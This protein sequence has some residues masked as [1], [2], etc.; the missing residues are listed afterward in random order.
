M[1]NFIIKIIIILIIIFV[2]LFL[3]LKFGG[4]LIPNVCNKIF[5]FGCNDPAILDTK[6][7]HWTK[8]FRDNWNVILQEYNNYTNKF[9]IPYHHQLNSYVSDCDIKRMWKT[10]YLRAYNTDTTNVELFP[11]T[12]ELINNSP[13]TLAFFSVLEPGAK[14][15]PHKGIYKGVIRYHLGLVVPTDTNNCFIVVDGKKLTWKVGSD[16]MFDDMF[17]HYVENNTDERRVVLFLDIKRNFK[18]PILNFINNLLLYFVKSND[19]L[20]DTLEKIN[21]NSLKYIDVT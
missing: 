2:T 12:M 9:D 14:L 5:E 6:D 15:A 10:L 7:Y 18:N 3:L 16:I 20:Q 17:E 13:C 21:E 19:V 8:N 4:Y 1:N 11:R